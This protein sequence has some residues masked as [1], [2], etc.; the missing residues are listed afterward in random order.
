[1]DG[2][3]CV[4]KGSVVSKR[5]QR[6]YRKNW[7]GVCQPVYKARVHNVDDEVE[8]RKANLPHSTTSS[9]ATT[10]TF[11]NSTS[12]RWQNVT[13]R[14]KRAPSFGH[15]GVYHKHA[16]PDHIQYHDNPLFRKRSPPPK[17]ASPIAYDKIYGPPGASPG[18]IHYHENPLLRKGAPSKRSGNA[19]PKPGGI[20]YHALGKNPLLNKRKH[21]KDRN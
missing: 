8:F 20:R 19:S 4:K 15:E 7:V 9:M 6:G 16:S 1:M 14:R 13:R 11:G 17:S 18:G 2:Y 10:K 21:K 12:S 3:H 5:C